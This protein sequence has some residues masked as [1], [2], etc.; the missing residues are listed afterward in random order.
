MEKT[1]SNISIPVSFSSADIQNAEA[2]VAK[3]QGIPGSI[4]GWEKTRAISSHLVQDDLG[5]DNLIILVDQRITSG[6]GAASNSEYYYVKGYNGTFP[7]GSHKICIGK[8]PENRP[9]KVVEVIQ[10]IKDEEARTIVKVEK[11][12]GK[13]EEVWLW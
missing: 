6:S 7:E 12:S 10:T 2:A 8:G 1:Q 13:I 11:Q 5:K 3:N 9:V 4:C